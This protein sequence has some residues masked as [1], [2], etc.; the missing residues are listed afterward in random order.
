MPAHVATS[1]QPSRRAGSASAIHPRTPVRHPRRSRSPARRPRCSASSTT[2]P[3]APECSRMNAISSAL[4][5]K[6]IGTRTTPSRASAKLTHRELPAVV[7]E[8]REPVALRHPA[9]AQRAAVAVHRGVELGVG[10]AQVAA[11]RAPACPGSAAPCAAAGR[12]SLASGRD[13]QR[14]TR[15]GDSGSGS[16]EVGLASRAPGARVSIIAP[17]MRLPRGTTPPA[18]ATPPRS[19]ASRPSSPGARRPRRGRRSARRTGCRRRR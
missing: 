9:R 5:M 16:R 13:A 18:P 10:P 15:M 7:G 6:L 1:S 11:R 2:I 8:Q 17:T 12:R 14:R 19:G 4:S 3:D